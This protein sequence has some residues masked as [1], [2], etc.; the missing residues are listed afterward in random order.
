MAGM[1]KP[2][3]DEAAIL[4]G[5]PCA[6]TAP[7][8][9]RWILAASILGSSMA[10][11]DGT[12]VN[13]ALPAIQADLRASTAGI[14]WVVESYALF[15][16]A[17]LLL[18]GS[19]GDLY[20]RRRIFCAGALLFSGASMWCGLAPGLGQLILARGLQGVGGAML[21]PGSLA[22]VSEAFPPERRGR[23]IGTWSAFTSITAAIGPLLGGWLVEH[24]SW[25]WAFFL[26]APL[27]VAVV[28]LAL[29]HVPGSR[30]DRGVPS[31]DWP[32]A[33]L[34]TIGLGGVVFALIES[35]RSSRSIAISAVLGACAIAA[36]VAYEKRSPAPMVP[37]ALFSSRTFA[38]ANLLTFLLYSALGGALFFLPLDLI[39][40]Q[41]YSATEAGAALLPF[42]L[43][44]FLLSRWSGGLVRR[45][46]AKPPL[47]IGPIIAAAGFAL[48]AT[49]GLGGPYATRVFPGVAVLGLGMAVSVAPLTTTVMSAVPQSRAGIASAINN[50]LSRVGG[51]LAIAVL[52]LVLSAVFNSALDR[53]LD[54]LSL[55]LEARR[56]V[57]VERPQLGAAQSS[58]SR[59]RRAISESFVEGFR[60]IQW[61]AAGLA[62]A[63][64]LSAAL[65]ITLPP[66][67]PS[68]PRR[69]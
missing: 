54:L 56:E 25:R 14:Q 42:I 9:A 24:A 47:V 64:S 37:L 65:L 20:G 26:N 50:A 28:V 38:G 3:C 19:L 16:A 52:G 61:I 49:S 21:I 48:L 32:G 34:A 4:A 66:A 6:P 45:Y 7:G 40:V 63:S 58:D 41:G 60:S 31:L 35:G 22:L 43:S 11:I 1:G 18:G 44:M 46:G 13:V 8:R 27:A 15:L 10:F 17:L 55:P 12:V 53:R 59:I 57:D 39:Q 29:L 2:P 23:A 5:A 69:E 62:V 67:R 30:R 33:V 68:A 51:L 36:F